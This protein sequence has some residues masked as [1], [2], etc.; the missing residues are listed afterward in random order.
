MIGNKQKIKVEV[1]EVKAIVLDPAKKYI[2][3]MDF[4]RDVTQQNIIKIADSLTQSLE[5]KG[6]TREQCDI[7]A[8]SGGVKIDVIEHTAV[9][10]AELEAKSKAAE[11]KAAKPKK[12]TTKK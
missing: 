1:Q 10:V 4:P 7:W 12:A 11:A 2:F 9:N 8:M 6:F 3:V 5:R